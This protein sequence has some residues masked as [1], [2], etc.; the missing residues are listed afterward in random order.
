LGHELRNPLAPI[1]TASDMLKLLGLGDPRAERA[2]AIIDRQVA[3][4]IH[5]VDDLLDVARI[6]RGTLVLRHDPADWAEVVRAG[7]EDRRAEFEARGIALELAVPAAPLWVS[8]DPTRLT[9]VLANLLGNALKFTDRGGRVEVRLAGENGVCDLVVR[10]TGV[11]MTAQTLARIFE[12]FEQAQ[13]DSAR[14][15]GGVGMGLALA[16][17]LV[18]LHGGAISAASAGP[19]RG[20][21]LRVRLPLTTAPAVRGAVAT[22]PVVDGAHVLIIED[23]RDAAESLRAFLEVTGCRVEVA[24]DGGAGL[25]AARAHPPE[26]ILC[27]IGLPGAPDGYGVAAAVRADPALHVSRLIALT[28]YGQPEDRERARQAGFDA[29]LTKPAEAEELLALVAHAHAR[30][31]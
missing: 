6:A 2:R 14:I 29:H 7:T 15:A 1:K 4:L 8:G 25:A 3:H 16:K 31:S 23:N 18:E 22:T 9:Q 10:D 26:I 19:G 30:P 11:G 13:Q 12:P 24:H 20:A 5:I 17:G 21:E 27:D 28:G